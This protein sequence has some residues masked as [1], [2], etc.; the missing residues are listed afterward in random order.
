L[1]DNILDENDAYTLEAEYIQK[2]GRENIDSGGILANICL[3]NRPPNWKGKKQSKEHIANRVDSYKKTCK[4]VG[5]KPHTKEA[6]RKIARYGEENAFYGKSHSD[7]FKQA[8][9]IRMK[10]NKNGAK[11]YIF[12]SPNGIDYI[13]I[14]GFA[15][16]C[17]DNNLA[18]STME[19][20]LYYNTIP[21]SGKCKGWKIKRYEGNENE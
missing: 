19:K 20:A 8:H 21:N 15:Q 14:G 12:T 17:K 18:V 4:T 3:D 7:E 1:V 11:K 2:Y 16:F 10:G 13:V 5:R 9:S 6:K